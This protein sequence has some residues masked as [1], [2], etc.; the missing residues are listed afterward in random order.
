MLRVQNRAELQRMKGERPQA[1][2]APPAPTVDV[3]G[4]QAAMERLGERF[5][6]AAARMAQPPPKKQL[7]AIVHR[8]RDG[9]MQ[10]VTITINEEK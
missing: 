1:E 5:E 8:D 7:E 10:K 4:L 9:R 2:P 6:Q 3:A